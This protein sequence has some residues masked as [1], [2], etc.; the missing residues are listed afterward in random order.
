MPTNSKQ[1][2]PNQ[3]EI[4][5]LTLFSKLGEFIKKAFLGLVNLIGSI[6]VFLLRKWYYFAVAVLLTIL[7]AYILNKIA[8]DIYQSDMVLKSNA[9]TN[10]TVMSSLDKLGDY[11]SNRYYAAL[12][13][14]LNIS[15]EDASKIKGLETFWLYDL[16]G[17]GIYDGIDI[18]ERYLSDT[19]VHVIENEFVL[20]L[21]LFD[22]VLLETLEE[23]LILYLEAQPY[24]IALNKQRLSE[25]EAQLNQTQYEIVK[26]DSLQK[27]EYFTNPDYLRQKE[28]QIVFTSEKTVK[29]YHNEM[30]QLLQL[31]QEC[32]KELN[33]YSEIVTVTEGFSMPV[34]PEHGILNYIKKIVWY[35]LAL[36]LLVAVLVTFRKKIWV[37]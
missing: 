21:S 36:G 3:D 13:N 35:Y 28:S 22:P 31:K 30:F 2:S 37:R 7:S 32:E 12:S 19:S 20:R 11:A 23:S 34:I 15:K 1:N 16:G 17:D 26:L 24:L 4:D 10:Q 6:L 8:V 9:T 18:E 29:T 27:R 5:L 14:E 33:I 25:L